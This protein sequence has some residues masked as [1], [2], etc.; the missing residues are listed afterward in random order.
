MLFQRYQAEADRRA[1]DGGDRAAVEAEV[2]AELREK[3]LGGRVL[4]AATASAPLS[5]EMAAFVESC[6]DV[7]LHDIYAST[8]AGKVVADRKVTRPPVLDYKLADVPEL[9]YFRTD[10]PHPRGEL[11]LRSQTIIPGYYKRPDVT[12]EI[13]DEDGYYRTGDIMAELGPAELVYVDRR[14]NVLKLSQGEFVAVSRLE[15]IFVSIPLVQQMF[16]YGNSERAYLLAVIVP[17][18]DAIMCVI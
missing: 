16:V 1:G 14:K 2:K 12:A 18:E 13:F 7:P 5:A 3:F 6:L 15:A 9:G 17:T 8:E 10:S 11:L 4:W